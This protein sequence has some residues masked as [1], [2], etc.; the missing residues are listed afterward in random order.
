M[1]ESK[2]LFPICTFFLTFLNLSIFL[3]LIKM[4]KINYLENIEI[5]IFKDW[6]VVSNFDNNTDNYQVEK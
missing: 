4:L 5:K 2:K 3:K 6:K 1:N